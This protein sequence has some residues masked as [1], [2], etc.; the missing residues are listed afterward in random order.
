MPAPQPERIVTFVAPGLPFSP[1]APW[2]PWIPRGPGSPFGPA[3]SWPALKSAAM[4]EPFFTLALVTAFLASFLPATAFFFNCTAPTEFLGRTSLLA[5]WPSE[6]E[7]KTATT[8][9]VTAMIVEIF[10]L[11]MVRGSLRLLLSRRR[12]HRNRQTGMGR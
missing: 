7:P 2:I 12:W 4:S 1:L 8:R 5:A 6:V 3:G 10:D 11:N 9:A